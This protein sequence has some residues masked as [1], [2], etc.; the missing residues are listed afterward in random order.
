MKKYIFRLDDISWDMNY[1]NFDRICSLFLKY[2]VR[3][4]IGVIPHNE[5]PKLKSFCKKNIS[6]KAF[7]ELI[8]KLQKDYGWAIAMHGFNH[9]YC[10]S[11]SGLMKKNKRSE[12]AGVSYD[13]QNDKIERG[14]EIFS[15]Q[16]VSIDAFMAPAHSFDKQ[17]LKALL[18]NK[19]DVITD[20]IGPYPYKRDGV[21]F[22]PQIWP[23][24]NKRLYGI[25]TVC[26]HINSWDDNLFAKLEDFLQ[27]NVKDSF[28][29][30]QEIV[31]D[32]KNGGRCSRTVEVFFFT[33]YSKAW[34]ML[35][36]FLKNI[37][38]K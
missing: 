7:W 11:D 6:E 22:V 16:G 3:P 32:A 27:R 20:G 14:I 29:S 28:L 23:W 15:K 37:V 25:D 13:I 1:E 10:S 31:S 36:R 38:G 5:D 4:I 24:P 2:D 33:L 19:I 35:A 26:F 21:L 12:F 9:L 18:N 17:T 8:R 34:Y 30:F